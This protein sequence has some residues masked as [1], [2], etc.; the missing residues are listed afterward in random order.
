MA[1]TTTTGCRS[2]RPFTMAATRSMALASCTDVPPNFITSMGGRTSVAVEHRLS[3]G[4]AHHSVCPRGLDQSGASLQ[5]ALRLKEF[6][7]QQGR[8]GS[9][10]DGVVRKH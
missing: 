9:P 2:R 1:L 6:G 10:T 8:A 4:A 3:C 5:V 7:I